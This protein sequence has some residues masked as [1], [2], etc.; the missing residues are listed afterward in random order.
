MNKNIAIITGASSGI[1][2]MFAKKIVKQYD[3]DEIWLVS[4]TKEKLEELKKEIE[5]PSKIISLDLIKKE[6]FEKIEKILDE[7]KPN[8][9]ILL[10]SS[11]YGIFDEFIKTK[12]EDCLGMIDLNCRALTEL[13]YLCIP[14]MKKDGTIINMASVA[15]FSPLPYGS[16]YA[17]S[18]AFVL[19]FSCS[20]NVELKKKQIHVLASCPYWTNTS[21]I[22]ESNPTKTIRKYDCMYETEFVVDK[23]IK[24]LKKK[25]DYVVPGFV[26]KFTHLM[27]KILPHFLI[28]KVFVHQQ[29]LDN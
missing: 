24:A 8:I 20:L 12:K 18:K 15:S 10:N 21:F 4:R 28:M 23:M 1:G 25:K 13:T 19:S 29:K 2:R 22:K 9:Q 16:I 14:Y 5:I 7:E 27:T 17:A 11:G 6:S 3:F 26:S